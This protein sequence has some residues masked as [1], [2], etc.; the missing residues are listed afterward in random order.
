VGALVPLEERID[1]L[2]AW[3]AANAAEA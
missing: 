2:R 1:A 3:L